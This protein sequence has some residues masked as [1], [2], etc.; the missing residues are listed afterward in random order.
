[1]TTNLPL[2]ATPPTPLSF[3]FPKTSVTVNRLGYGAMRLTGPGVWGAPRDPKAAVDLLREAVAAGVNHIDTAEF[4][5]PHITN[6]LIREALQPYPED[7]VIVTK[8]GVQ[9]G[10]DKS[11]RPA[12]RPEDLEAAVHDNL[13]TLG[14]DT[15]EVVN[16]RVGSPQG[17]VEGSIAEPFQALLDLQ[18]QGLI[19]QL[20][21][22][23]VTARQIAEAQALGEFVCVQNH[24]H[25][26]NRGDD[27]LI[28]DLAT[29]GIAYVPYFP[30]GG[31][32][33]LRSPTLNSVAET[34]QSSPMQVALAWLLQRSPNI[35]LIPGTSSPSHLR[36]NLQASS[37]KIPSDL[38]ATLNELA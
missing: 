2:E 3:T 7:L 29:R 4:Y 11:W 5:G 25:L 26:L 28:K 27:C 23:N 14:L 37:L 21:L 32:S 19:R 35:L 34:L 12:L 24:Y 17:A 6:Q 18:K 13:C 33:P 22:S 16:L 15:L 10:P 38:M 36:E 30:L 31:F 9:R 8:V 20:G 1:M